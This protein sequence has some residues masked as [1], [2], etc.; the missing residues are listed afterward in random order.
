MGSSFAGK[1]RN[2]PQ[3]LKKSL[4]GHENS[5]KNENPFRKLPVV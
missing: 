5:F 2:I 3:A 4:A 1:A